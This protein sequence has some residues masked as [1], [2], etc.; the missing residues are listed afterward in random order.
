MKYIFKK[1][2]L[3]LLAVVTAILSPVEQVFAA[4]P[5]LF[6]N[7]VPIVSKSADAINQ[8]ETTYVSAKSMGKTFA[9]ID[10]TGFL[11]VNREAREDSGVVGKVY[12]DSLLEIQERSEEWTRISSGNV[13]GYVRT[14]KLVPE[15]A[16][17]VHAKTLMEKINP[18]MNPMAYNE[19]VVFADLPVGETVEEEANRLAEEEARRI[20]EEEAARRA[21]GQAVVDY[22]KQFLGNPYV[23]GGTSLT[24]GTDCSGFVLSVYAKF[25]FSLPHSSYGQ[26]SV[27]RRVSYSEIQPGDI[28]CYPGHVGIYAG[29]GKIIHAS[30][31]RSGIKFSNAKYTRIVAIRRMF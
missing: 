31:E 1:K 25:G 30:D 15:S 27:G 13:V 3:V 16:A 17:L 11:Q 28:I 23:Y 4:T 9:M 24:R 26:R 2:N 21:K 6:F 14:E 12:Q 7:Q 22:A 5:N 8:S 10:E 19:E 18:L 20:A 29:D